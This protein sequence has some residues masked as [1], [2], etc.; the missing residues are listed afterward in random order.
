MATEQGAKRARE[1]TELMASTAEALDQ[2][3]QTTDQQKQAAAQ[4]SQTMLE[5][6]RAV[7][8]LADEQRQRKI[9][10]ERVESMIG[11][12]TETLSEHGVA[13][14]GHGRDGER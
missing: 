7:E 10:A 4:V 14:N 6:R 12:L 3:I 9:T 2:S 11:D 8:E 5:I 13:L 1:V